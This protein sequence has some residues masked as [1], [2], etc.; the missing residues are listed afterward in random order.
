MARVVVVGAG[1]AGLCS[2]LALAD[3]GHDV[4]VLE[5]GPAPGGQLAFGPQPFTLPAVLRDLFRK[6]GRP[7]ERELDVVPVDPAVRW[8]FADGVEVAVPNASP[9]GARRALD[10]TFGTGAGAQWDAVVAHG[11][12]SWRESRSLVLGHAG[13]KPAPSAGTLRDVAASLREPR[14]RAAL[15]SYATRYGADPATAPAALT[16]LP[17]L[18]QTFGVWTTPLP[19]LVDVL[20]GRAAERGAAFRYGAPATG[21]VLDGRR[22][23]GV[24]LAGGETLPADAV[25]WT[26]PPRLL[27][28]GIAAERRV[29]FGRRRGHREPAPDAVRTVVTPLPAGSEPDPTPSIH[30]PAGGDPA[31]VTYDTS[32]GRVEHVAP[33]AVH[34]AATGRVTAIFRRPA[35]VT[36]IRGLYLAGAGAHPGP[37]IPLVALSAAIVT[38]QIGRA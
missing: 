15:V 37:G 5:S 36:R 23:T 4:T 26:A 12:R 18:E 14:L 35:N 10:E 33:G 38:D 3:F 17:Y 2:A 16:A 6:T 7:L 21:P 29:P 22:L 11:D 32:E 19:R 8:V 28:D 25:V 34:G 1:L 20:A 30:L 31:T 9:S 13:A 24:A 27:P